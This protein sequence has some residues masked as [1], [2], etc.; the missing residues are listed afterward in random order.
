MQ[1]AELHSQCLAGLQHGLGDP[2]QHRVTRDQRAHPRRKLPFADLAHL[3]PE[4]AQKTPQAE[5]SSRILACSCL[6]ATSSARTSW[7]G[8]DLQWTGRNQPIRK[9]WAMP[10]ASLRSVLT[11]IAESAAFTCLVNP[12]KVIHGCPSMCLG[13]ITSDPG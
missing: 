7:A 2:L 13:P 11:I 9:S 4:A 10:R 8:A 3:E 1:L 12:G 5:L 6:R